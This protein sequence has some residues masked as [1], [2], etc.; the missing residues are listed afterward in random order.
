[1]LARGIFSKIVL[2]DRSNT[3]R[4]LNILEEKGLVERHVDTKQ[5]RLV[6]KVILTPKG[7]ALLE[8]IFP[9]VKSEYI[10]AYDGISDEEI[11]VVR[12]VLEKMKENL[13]KD[14]TI[15]I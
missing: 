13:S 10:K 7:A 6:K 2:K 9:V 14:T 8:R 3:S 5:K 12:K 1:M 15:Q 4:I 11:S